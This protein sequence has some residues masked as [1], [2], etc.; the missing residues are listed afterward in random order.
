MLNLAGVGEPGRTREQVETFREQ[1][2]PKLRGLLA[3]D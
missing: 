3:R 1:R 2:L